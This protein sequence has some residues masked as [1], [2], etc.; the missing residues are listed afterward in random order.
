MKRSLVLF[1]IFAVAAFF[2]L[3]SCGS[4]GSG[5][6]IKVSY[7]GDA[8]EIEIIDSIVKP[9]DKG[10]K[11]IQVILEHTPS[12]RYQDKVL[13]QIAGGEAP[14]VMFCG[15][16]VF[17]SLYRKNVFL[18]INDLLAADTEINIKDYYPE[19]VDQYTVD[20]KIN[21]LPRDIA[22]IACIY[23]NK[24]LFDAE[25]LPY[26]TDDWNTDE[27]LALAKKLTKKDATGIVAQYGF[28]PGWFWPNFIFAFGAGWVDNVKKP[29]KL[30]LN[31]PGVKAGMKFYHDLMWVHGVSP[32]PGA[33]DQTGSDLFMTGRTA[34]YSSGIWETPQFRT[35]TAFD[36]DVVMFPK[37]PS[38]KRG[39]MGGGSGY[40]I[41]SGTKH[42]KEAWEVVKCLAGDAGQI[43]MAESGLAQPAK[44]SLVQGEHFGKDGQKPLNKI[45]LDKAVQYT[46]GDVFSGSFYEIQ[47]SIIYPSLDEYSLNKIPLE[48][49]LAKIDREVKTKGLTL[50]D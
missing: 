6:P 18:P 27:F 23:I 31:T 13:A 4:K 46:I 33:T 5:I 34:M 32:K 14:D 47:S 15:S 8:K 3:S 17:I 19:S 29:T 36:W 35:I 11:D 7:W 1:L 48:D 10:R 30:A 42:P 37:T 41:Y 12:N 24:N 16:T 9:W 50:K 22:P 40:G 20:G 43:I 25:G 49:A 38:G 45:M 2:G 26:P 44:M 39:F 28:S 21:A